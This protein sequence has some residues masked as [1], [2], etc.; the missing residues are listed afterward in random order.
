M[1]EPVDRAA[2]DRIALLSAWRRG[3]AVAVV[4]IVVLTAFGPLS[5]GA[6][7]FAIAVALLLAATAHLSLRLFLARC[8]FEPNLARIAAVARFRRR[9]CSPRRRRQHAAHLRHTAHPSRHA[10]N[11]DLVAWDR[12]RLVQAQLLALADELEAAE[13]VDPRTMVDLDRLLCDS[14]L[15]P[16]LNRAIPEPELF[17]TVRSIRY[18]VSSAPHELSASSIA[19]RESPHGWGRRAFGWRQRAGD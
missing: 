7:L 6:G 11:S 16:L 8:V 10:L 19:A 17:V 9:Q 12:V 4:A 1:R 15:S 2:R 3:G 5:P 14:C 18:R 13:T